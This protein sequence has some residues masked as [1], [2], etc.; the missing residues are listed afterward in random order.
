MTTM[1][2]MAPT[3]SKAAAAARISRR[4]IGLLKARNGY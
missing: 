2:M 4:F 1:A 3:T